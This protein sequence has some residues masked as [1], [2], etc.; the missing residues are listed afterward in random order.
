MS[1]KTPDSSFMVKAVARF[2][3]LMLILPA[4]LFI[5]AGTVNW[6]MA[7][8]YSIMTIGITA[9]SRIV[10]ARA[11]PELVSERAGQHAQEGV[12]E[13]DKKI[14]PIVGFLGP[15]VML[16]VCGLDKR[17][18][19][20]LEIP[21][22]GQVAALVVT[23][24]AALWATWAMLSNKFYS[25]TVRIQRDRGHT[26]VDTGPYRFMRHPSYLGGIVADVAGP[27]SLGSLWA[28]VPGVLLSA[29]IVHRTA[30]EDK[31]LLAELDGYNEYA[32]RVRYRLLP[33][34]W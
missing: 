19:W 34:V 21:L 8:L 24:A 33:G 9:G 20:S 22:S 6:P 18:G 23:A 4:L 25:A 32:R 26:V 30:R 2:A 29:I 12:Q 3:I 1:A 16:I 28:L 15:L 17:W 10:M 5:S 14:L 11:N 27:L 31:A 13:W 7:W